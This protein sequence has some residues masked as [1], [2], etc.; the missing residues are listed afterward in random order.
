M[1]RVPFRKKDEDPLV[2]TYCFLMDR[3]D[4]DGRWSYGTRYYMTHG[5]IVSEIPS[6]L[7]MPLIRRH[8]N[9]LT[10]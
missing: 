1:G 3:A 9:S 2:R 10:L 4:K 7:G 6:W 5:T 8:I